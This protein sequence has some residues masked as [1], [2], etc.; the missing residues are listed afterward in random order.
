MP[1]LAPDRLPKLRRKAVKDQAGKEYAYAVVELSGEEIRLGA[2]GSEESVLK[3]NRAV[4]EWQAAGR[5]AP[6]KRSAIFTVASLAAGYLAWAGG[7]YLKNGKPTAEFKKV[8]KAAGELAD[9]Y[10]DIPAADFGPTKLATLRDGWVRSGLARK[11]VNENAIRVRQFFRWGVER[12]LVSATVLEALKAMKPL[13]KGRTAAP[14]HPPIR[15][16]VPEHL[17]A[18]LGHLRPRVADMLRLIDLTAMRPGE[19]VGIRPCDVDRSPGR[20]WK[21]AVTD[22]WNKNAHKHQSRTVWIGPKAQAILGPWLDR[23]S[24][25]D[26]PV[27]R[28]QVSR[29]F[30]SPDSIR[31]ITKRACRRAGVPEFTPNQLRHTS[32]TRIR[33]AMGLEASGAVLG[34]KDIN[35][36]QIYAE[37]DET[38][39]V[40]AAEILG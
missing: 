34:H 22:W 25:V 33:A 39:A 31:V 21:Y 38:L 11:T 20:P 18:A 2:F 16:V 7:Y 17:A 40:N 14:D 12:E 13:T 3:Y 29:G 27:F 19:V 10:G 5:K 6:P 8:R 24:K 15:C 32:A 36:T 26:I 37:R 30:Y 35:T 1:K 4:A 28:S 23:T 9:L